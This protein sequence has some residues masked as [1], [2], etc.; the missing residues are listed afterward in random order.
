[1]N[2][3]CKRSFLS[4]GLSAGVLLMSG[5]QTFRA[6]QSDRDKEQDQK[7][8]EVVGE[9]GWILYWALQPVDWFE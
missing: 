2:S 7:V 3:C 6:S 4:L 8:G 5:C 9:T 1:M